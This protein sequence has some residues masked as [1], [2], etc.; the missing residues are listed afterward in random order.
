[1]AGVDVGSV[2][3]AAVDDTRLADFKDPARATGVGRLISDESVLYPKDDRGIIDGALL[4]EWRES[5]AF[6]QYPQ[7]STADRLS[8]AIAVLGTGCGAG[9]LQRAQAV[10][11]DVL[12]RF[13][14]LLDPSIMVPLGN[15]FQRNS[16]ASV[17]VALATTAEGA[18]PCSRDGIDVERLRA[19]ASA[20]SLRRAFMGAAPKRAYSDGRPYTSA[21][22]HMSGSFMRNTG[23]ISA[24]P[25]FMAAVLELE[26]LSGK[27]LYGTQAHHAV[28][29]SK[30]ESAILRSLGMY[31]M[32]GQDIK[33]RE[34]TSVLLDEIERS[35][36][37]PFRARE[38]VAFLALSATVEVFPAFS[39]A[40][41]QV[42]MVTHN[43][44][45]VF[46]ALVKLK[47]APDLT[48]AARLI[49]EQELGGSSLL[50]TH[51]SGAIGL[52]QSMDEVGYQLPPTLRAPANIAS[53]PTRANYERWQ[54]AH[55]MVS[56]KQAM[57]R[58]LS[59]D[60][61]QPTP[62]ELPRN[63]SLRVV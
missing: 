36:D 48:S 19:F 24:T 45:L 12:L 17:L 44:R 35:E 53:A 26:R 38:L 9:T 2:T 37:A 62:A 55:S 47:L 13:P 8:A 59:A 41:I 29:K 28:R 1:M 3:W 57:T 51:D 15:P 50:E 20:P 34:S 21:K 32:S 5:V 22:V 6:G 43:C 23:P 10:V 54:R 39:P 30:F 58:V 63:R 7:A 31:Y 11:S 56:A 40:V 14:A 52:M 42:P 27:R 33:R 25:R 60:Q 46:D 16:V 4:V 18:L 61:N 49:Y